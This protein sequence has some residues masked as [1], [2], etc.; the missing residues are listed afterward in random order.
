VV[1][2]AQIG[3]EGLLKLS[4]TAFLC[5]RKV[6]ASTVLRCYDWAIAQREAGTCIIS[7][8]HSTIEKNVLQYLIKGKQPII[9][10][11]ARGLKEKVEP[12]LKTPF[13]QGRILFVTPFNKKVDR[14][15]T[16][17]AIKR[18]QLMI[19]LADNIVV[20]YASK[21]G[22]LEKLLSPMKKP[23]QYLTH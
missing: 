16:E 3:N 11:L 10:A 9:V 23:V 20:G 1:I 21:G 17:T 8:F 18:N 12:E 6:P 4:K 22:E 15:I 5:S 7:G 14:V 2:K 13:E 19:E